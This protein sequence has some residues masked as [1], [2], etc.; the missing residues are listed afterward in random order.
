MAAYLRRHAM[1]DRVNLLGRLD[2]LDVRGVLGASHVFLAPADLESFG[3]AALEARCVGLPVVAKAN[4]GVSEFIRHEREGLLCGSDE[5]M[6]DAVVRLVRDRELRLR[7][8]AHNR[9]ADSPVGWETLLQKTEAAYASA[10][11]AQAAGA[12]TKSRRVPERQRS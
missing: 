7:I 4:S 8:A 6:A 3:I 10:C 12:Q 11:L 2:R 9:T 1:T 5:D